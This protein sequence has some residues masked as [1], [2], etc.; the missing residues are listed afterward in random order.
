MKKQ[1]NKNFVA[2][3]KE[4]EVTTSVRFDIS[5]RVY[6]YFLR[7]YSMTEVIYI[8]QYVLF[9]LMLCTASVFTSEEGKRKS[10][11]GSDF[12]V[13]VGT[14]GTRKSPRVV[15]RTTRLTTVF[16]MAC[17]GSS[18]LC[19]RAEKLCQFGHFAQL[20]RKVSTTCVKSRPR[21]DQQTSTLI[22]HC[23]VR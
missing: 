8:L 10:R 19:A 2:D 16:A 14:S 5:S 22:Q 21:I 6:P 15:R 12:E 23:Q 11:W 7:K 20:R 18:R 1:I 13:L 17:I 4:K 3:S 9:G